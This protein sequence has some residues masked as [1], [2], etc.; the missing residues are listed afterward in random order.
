MNLDFGT[1]GLESSGCFKRCLMS[2][3]GRS[4]EDSGA[5]CDLMNCVGQEISKEKNVGLC[6][7]TV[8]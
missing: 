5:E 8:L 2:H 4:K 7:E 3:T 1:L 6:L